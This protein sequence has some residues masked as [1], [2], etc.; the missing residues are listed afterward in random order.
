VGADS[1]LPG[2][3]GLS[4]HPEGQAASLD[5]AGAELVSEDWDEL[6]QGEDNHGR[7][8][9]DGAWTRLDRAAHEF[10][11]SGFEYFIDVE[12]H[13]MRSTYVAGC[14][15]APCTRANTAYHRQRRNT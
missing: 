8:R 7:K 12:T 2:L 15:C 3:Q 5:L 6:M 10:A 13:G 1:P 9:V 11:E 14:R 4:P